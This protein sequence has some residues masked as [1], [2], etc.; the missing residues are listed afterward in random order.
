MSPVHTCPNPP[1]WAK[2]HDRLQAEARELGIT[3][4]PP[5]PLILNGW[6]FSSSAEKHNRWEAT[7]RWADGYGLSDII[8]TMQPDQFTTWSERESA[9]EPE[10][11]EEE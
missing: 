5:K 3:D 1:D 4:E 7:K 6:V 11:F 8:A 9:W 10:P 2:I